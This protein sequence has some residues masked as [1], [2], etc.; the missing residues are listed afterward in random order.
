MRLVDGRVAEARREDGGRLVAREDDAFAVRAA[1]D[2][3]EGRGERHALEALLQLA[4]LTAIQLLF[5][6]GIY[7]VAAGFIIRDKNLAYM[8]P[9]DQSIFYPDNQVSGVPTI[10]LL[11]SL[12]ALVLVAVYMKEDAEATLATA[13]PLEFAI[14][15]PSGIGAARQLGWVAKAIIFHFA[16]CSRSTLVP[17]LT[18]MCCAVFFANTDNALDLVL[19]CTHP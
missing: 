7:D 13:M 2:D 14:L 4:S 6:F 17:A 1:R 5:A 8:P 16:T 10:N 15:P 18:G 11:M 3:V 9:L 19:N 12:I